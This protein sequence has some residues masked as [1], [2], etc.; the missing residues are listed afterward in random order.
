MQSER[1]LCN[2]NTS[3]RLQSA[4]L[5][6]QHCCLLRETFSSQ[7]AL[8]LH[9]THFNNIKAQTKGR[10]VREEFV[11]FLDL[12]QKTKTKLCY[13]WWVL[14]GSPW[15][16]AP[17]TGSASGPRRPGRTWAAGSR[18]P[19]SGL[20]APGRRCGRSPPCC[21]RPTRCH[22]RRRIEWRMSCFKPVFH[23]SWS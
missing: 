21:C 11:K 22:L 9:T 10:K 16:A 8:Y 3:G 5:T 17:R 1:W 7:L 19:A 6:S 23:P 18:P 15:P 20:S 4:Y 12:N 2:T 13:L 14:C